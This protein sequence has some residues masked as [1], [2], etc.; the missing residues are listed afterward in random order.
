MAEKT[1]Q[2]F[3]EGKRVGVVTNPRVDNFDYYG[4]WQPTD[5]NELYR[6]FLDQIDVDGGAKIE[7]GEIGSPLTGTV[8][9]EPDDEIEVKIRPSV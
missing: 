9:L 8:E 6:R 2:V 3:W 5:D 7:I 4:S 1:E